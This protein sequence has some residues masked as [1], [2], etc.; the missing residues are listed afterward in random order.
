M[1]QIVITYPAQ[2]MQR[3]TFTFESMICQV[4]TAAMA[5]I[6]RSTSQGP[7]DLLLGMQTCCLLQFQDP[8]AGGYGGAN[9]AADV[10]EEDDDGK[11]LYIT[12]TCRSC[13]DR[14]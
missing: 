6:Y 9:N 10:T 2:L 5:W 12:L 7:P 14:A 1:T 11:S 3:I 4:D 13:L 8:S